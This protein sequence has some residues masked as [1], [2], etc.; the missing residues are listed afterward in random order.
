MKVNRLIRVA[1]GDYKLD[2]IPAGMA[3]EVPFKPLETQDNKGPL[4]KAKPDSKPEVP[5]EQE[6]SPIQ[7]VRPV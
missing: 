3:I 2:T 6:T 1:Y 5:L 4:F 7:W